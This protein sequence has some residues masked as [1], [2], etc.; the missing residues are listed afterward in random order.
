MLGILI[1][2]ASFHSFEPL[3]RA[4][5]QRFVKCPH[6]VYILKTTPYGG[7]ASHGHQLNL[8]TLL[9]QAWEECDSFL[10]FDNDMIFL[11]DFHEPNE[12]CWYYPQTRDNEYPWGRGIEYAWPNLFYFKKDALLRQIWFEEGTDS[13]GSTWK[14]LKATVEKQQMFPD[15]EN[16][17]E[18]YRKQIKQLGEKYG[19]GVWAELYTL[20]GCSIFH[21]RAMSNW[22]NYPLDYMSKK[23]MLI[24]SHS[25]KYC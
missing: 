24:Q 9:D 10:F 2:Y 4:N 25:L 11:S 1:C 3:Q 21:F 16:G 17:L 18:E 5:I 22:A 12:K 8:N 13:G 6:K 7:G 14:Y 15:L 23:E 19:I 20:N